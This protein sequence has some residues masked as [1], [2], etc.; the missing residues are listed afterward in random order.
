MF[1]KLQK[2]I[3]KIFYEFVILF[4]YYIF[5]ADSHGIDIHTKSDSWKNIVNELKKTSFNDKKTNSVIYII[6]NL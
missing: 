3:K 4:D 1:Q 6:S 2:K 5:S